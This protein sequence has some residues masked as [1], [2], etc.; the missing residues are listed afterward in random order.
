[1]HKTGSY[2]PSDLATVPEYKDIVLETASIL[3]GTLEDSVLSDNMLASMENDVFLFSALKTHAQLFEASRMLLTEE[4]TIKPFLL[5]SNDIRKIKKNYNENYLEAEYDFAVGAVQ[6]AERWESFKDDDKYF[7]QYRTSNDD[8]VRKT[9]AVLDGITLPKNDA[10]WDY[11]F[12]PNGW[13]CRCNV[14][15]V[16]AHLNQKSNSDKAIEMGEKATT[17]IGKN[18]ENKLGIFRFNPAKEKVIFPPKHPYHKLAGAS[19][20]TA[21][22]EK[23][24]TTELN[25]NHL[26]KAAK[27]QLRGFK[28]MK[29]YKM[30]NSDEVTS[31]NLYT[32]ADAYYLHIN[33]YIRLNKI[34]LGA[35]AD[36][37]NKENLTTITKVINNGL[38]KIPDK[39][40]GIVYRGTTLPKEVLDLYK[41]SF[42]SKTP[43]VEKGFLSTSSEKKFAFN[44]N[45]FFIIK[46]KTGT[47]IDKLSDLP[48]EKE[49]LFKTNKKFN[50]LKIREKEEEDGKMI[51]EITMEEI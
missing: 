46:S 13:R 43:V 1:M 6:M 47:K 26:Y 40:K 49:V 5:F 33:N 35:K 42:K 20:V 39:H 28:E 8:K 41:Q 18:G 21:N 19:K 4:K 9:H 29:V 22:I 48:N 23:I 51:T 15:Q 10:F 32:R 34:A 31:I 12:A 27:K 44:G 25:K 36:G 24:D 30:L 45:H 16:L 14:V 3:N 2:S 50:I 38:D 17:Q 7:L 11:Y 37:F